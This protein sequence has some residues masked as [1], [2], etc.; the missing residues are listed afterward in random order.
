MSPR[1]GA[2]L[3]VGHLVIGCATPRV[4]RL[5]TGEGEPI[6]YAPPRSVTPIAIDEQS[7]EKALLGLILEM[8]FSVASDEVKRPRIRW[9]SWENGASGSERT[10]RDY[11]SWCSQQGSPDECLTLLGGGLNLLDKQARRDLALSFAWD[12]VWEGVQHSVKEVVHPLA[13]KAMLTSALAAYMLLV[14]MPEPVTK[15]VA[16]ALTTYFVAY[17]GLESFFDLVDGWRRLSME[18]E[19]AMSFEELEDSGHRFGKVMGSNGARVIIMALTM[20]LG[21]GAANMASKG[22][23][24]PGFA[25]ATLAAETNAGIQL[26][27]T[28]AG[29]VRS[30]S[31]A[32]GVMTVGL[33]PHAVAMV[34]RGPESRGGPR[35]SESTSTD[36]LQNQKP[37]LLAAE[38][39]LAQRLG[40][41]PTSV[42]SLEFL[43]YVN[44]GRIKWVVTQEGTL[45]IVPHT[46]RR[47]EISHAVASE[48]RPVL[49]AGEADIA[50]HGSTR[51]GI[52]I[53]PHS[54]HFLY[55]A[56]SARSARALELGKQA[57]AE[58]G[59][60][61]P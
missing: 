53:T 35:A 17:L 50:V 36:L 24:L 14:V 25:R 44:E 16:L 27:A 21:G 10:H 18:S 49:A 37:Q 11:Q 15:L 38:L 59:I 56:S 30:I 29:G 40:V 4:V 55:G 9:A 52:E 46:W 32:E 2:L 1:W 23:M 57:F 26:S 39:E 33:A 60:I 8:R 43:R 7:F 48:G 31:L 22:P 19:Q 42:T 58:A 45:R 20:A 6:V 34:A 5:D 41:H 61:F 12:G 3:L 51:M 54:G 13:L 28:F 47:T